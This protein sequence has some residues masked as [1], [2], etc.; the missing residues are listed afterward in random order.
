MTQ[1]T[2]AAPRAA[3]KPE[4]VLTP[5]TRKFSQKFVRTAKFHEKIQRK[6]KKIALF[7][8]DRFQLVR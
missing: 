6:R 5:T 2:T 8:A 7:F 1:A 4:T 3:E